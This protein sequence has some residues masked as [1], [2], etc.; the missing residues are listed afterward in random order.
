MKKEKELLKNDWF[1]IT[2]NEDGLLNLYIL[3]YMQ[4]VCKYIL[5]KEGIKIPKK[6]QEAHEGTLFKLVDTIIPGSS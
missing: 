6:R 4:D 2:L 5:S 3:T 1:R